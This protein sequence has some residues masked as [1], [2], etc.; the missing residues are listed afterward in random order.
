MRPHPPTL[1]KVLAI[2]S[3]VVFYAG[4]AGFAVD[5]IFS[6]SGS[7]TALRT[8]AGGSAATS[9]GESTTS[10]DGTLV[11]G[12]T[13]V[14][15][16][17]AASGGTSATGRRAGAAGTSGATGGG[18]GGTRSGAVAGSGSAGGTVRIGI[19]DDNPGAAFSQFGVE[20]GPSG[21]QQAHIAKIV[22]WINANG[23]MGGRKVETV[24]H[25]TESLNGTFD[26]QAERAC[27]EFTE[28]NKVAAVVGG[29]RV[30]TLNLIDCLA[31]HNT[32]LIW[33]FQF[34]VDNGILAKYDRYLYM[35]NMVSA[36]RLGGWVDALAET[37][38]L[39][40]AVVGVARY[41][42]PIHERFVNQ[43]LAPRLAAKGVAIKE[44]AAFRN[45]QAASS[46]ADL[47][48]QANN[49]ILRFRSS[50][51]NR[52][53]F[54]PTSAVMPLLWFAAAESQ[55]YRPRYSLT[56]MDNP[57]FQN[58]N[59]GDTRQ[60]EGSI[61][62]GWLPAGDVAWPEQPA[63]NASQK[64]CVDITKDATPPGNGAIRRF[65]DGLMLLKAIFDRGAE[66]TPD[67]IKRGIEALGT[68]YESAWT[69]QANLGP[70]R[71]DGPA[72]ARVAPYDLGCRCYKYTGPP[73][74]IP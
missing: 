7:S 71:H 62:Y 68:S 20:G 35:P 19:H 11:A 70:G 9:D 72:V 42:D 30:P 65:C 23:G 27:A 51:V 24:P 74:P 14:A 28:D 56:S 6:E 33:N 50:G 26:Q 57:A 47:S 15:A 44:Q 41:D 63:L 58:D 32:P 59:A 64:R 38:F 49:A 54:V 55:S 18:A 21:D 67:G 8:T 12:E 61:A 16:G 5:E 3:V 45:A 60:L 53:L 2:A 69:F 36:D 34:M 46:A 25:V 4:V 52:V 48:A 39:K 10:G 13:G 1:T 29:A 73:R 40:D 43:V 17:P 22:E 66:P 31:R 37:G